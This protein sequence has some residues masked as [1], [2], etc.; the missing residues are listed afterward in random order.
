VLLGGAGPVHGCEVA[1]DL[2]ITTL[3]VPPHP[4]LLAAYGLLVSD[5]THDGAT[6]FHGT[7]REI[8][9]QSLRAACDQLDD[10]GRKTLAADGA[11]PQDVSVRF[12]AQ[13][14]YVGQSFELD[15][16]L[17][18]R[19]SP[20]SSSEITE[21]FESRHLAAYGRTS[22][23]RDIE[24][25]SLK[26]THAWRQPRPPGIRPPASGDFASARRGSRKVYDPRLEDFCINPVFDRKA[27]AVGA[28]IQGP[29]IIEQLDTTTVLPADASAKVDAF[30]TLI[31]SLGGA[32]S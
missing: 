21:A 20:T 28:E 24:F 16:D 31:V 29:C 25:V 18:S 14:R 6:S 15:V 32:Q 12:S 19:S 3:I 30:G 11:P 10:E 23:E 1:R 5:V 17:P 4:G 27:L 7:L 13:M 8:D 22:P 2:G 26:A 9:P